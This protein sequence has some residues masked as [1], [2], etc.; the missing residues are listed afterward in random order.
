MWRDSHK[1]KQIS[2]RKEI[3]MK[4]EKGVTDREGKSFVSQLTGATRGQTSVIHLPER[5]V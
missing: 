5:G 1:E 3:K 2:E 4:G